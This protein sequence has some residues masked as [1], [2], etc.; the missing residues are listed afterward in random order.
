MVFGA[1]FTAYFFIRV[2]RGRRVAGRGHRAAE[3]DRGRQHGDPA[4]LVVH[5]A[6][7]AEYAHKTDNRFGL[8]AG[9][10]TTFLLGATFLFIQINEYV[11]IGFSPQD[12]AQGTIFYGLTGL[13]GA[14]VFIGLTLLPFVTIRAF[15]G[16]FTAE[17]HRGV[18]VPGIYWHFVDVMW[19]V[20]YIDGLHHLAGRAQPAALGG[21]GVPLPPLR[22]RRGVVVVVIV[23]IVA[24]RDLLGPARP[25][26]ARGVSTPAVLTV[27]A[28]AV[29]WLVLA[30]G[31]Y[32]RALRILARARRRA[33][34]AGRSRCWHLGHRAARRS[35]CS[36]PL[37][38]WRDE[39]LSAH[40][41]QH[42]LIADLGA[43][44]LLA[45]M[46]NPVA[47]LLPPAR[48]CSCRSRAGAGCAR[49]SGRC[50]SRSWRSRLRARALRLA[51]RAAFEAAVRHALVHALQH[52]SFVAPGCSCGGRR[53]SRSAAACAATCGRS[54]TSSP[55]GC[56]ACSSGWASCSSAMPVYT[57]VYGAPASAAGS[58]A[59]ADQQTA[60]A[61]MV[62]LDI[63]IMVFALALLLL[64]RRAA[65]RPR[66]GRAPRGTATRRRAAYLTV[67]LPSMPPSRWPGTEQ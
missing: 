60:G 25:R 27:D 7:G 4:L 13:H 11:H 22:H 23:L 35:G 40:M 42:L 55:R 67:S 41:A 9:M 66:R 52:A 46:R 12:S 32:V 10:F 2:V 31:L 64:A 62:A 50:A 58:S 57:G 6:L 65:V 29:V 16:H 28:R 47:G 20:V 30:E 63:L 59:L 19:V 14:H 17:E 5:A 15:R 53:W 18:E 26:S 33:C 43:P 49:R 56:S 21:R 36:R 44:L 1:F 51:P 38:R 54:A 45:G 8:Q 3:A 61:M 34:R 24:L 48:R 39:L 37:D